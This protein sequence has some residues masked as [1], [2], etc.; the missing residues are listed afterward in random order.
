[1]KIGKMLSPEGGLIHIVPEPF[2]AG[3]DQAAK[4]FPPPGPRGRI[5][6]IR[7]VAS[8]RPDAADV[9]IAAGVLDKKVLADPL[10]VCKI[11]GFHLNTGVDN[12]HQMKP[13]AL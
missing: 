1:Y 3:I 8:S 7:E 5:G 2:H 13:Q 9:E 11:S 4:R 10:L 6:K 12:G